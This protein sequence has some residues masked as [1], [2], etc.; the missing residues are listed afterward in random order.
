VSE[1]Y[2]R[3]L[4]SIPISSLF[5]AFL[6]CHGNPQIYYGPLESRS[7]DIS[8]RDQTADTPP[9]TPSIQ[10]YPLFIYHSCFP[11]SAS[12][13]SIESHLKEVG[14]VIPQRRYT[15]YSTTHFHSTTHEVLCVLTG[16]AKLCMTRKD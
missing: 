4:T 3:N 6:D 2:N 12:A 10:Q 7:F 15:L 16:R 13:S 11:S 1:F 14:V 5:I 9:Q 8:P